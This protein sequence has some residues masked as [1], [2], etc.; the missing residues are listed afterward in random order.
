MYR[1]T[2]RR[3]AALARIAQDNHPEVFLEAGDT[4]IFSSRVIP[5]N[6]REVGAI[7]NALSKRGVRIITES[8]VD[9]TVHVTGHPMREEL[10]ALM[11]W[12]RPRF[13]LPV[14]GEWRHLEAHAELAEMN[15]VEKAVVGGNGAVIRLTQD[16][17][18]VV[19]RVY[20]GRL[21][22][23]GHRLI[24][25]EG[26]LLP[27]RRRL[28]RAGMVSIGVALDHQG[29]MVGRISVD[30]YGSMDRDVD[31]DIINETR[32]DVAQSLERLDRKRR[33]EDGAVEK[34]IVASV[35]QT[36]QDITGKKPL[37]SV[38]IIRI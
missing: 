13:V 37:V 16:S 20:S 12:I 32:N 28:A 8:D 29:K 7:Q 23:D 2:R 24:D 26:L 19:D 9:E 31:G 38:H 6:E 10:T 17:A 34:T 27:Q 3:R 35:K 21:A 36:F 22:L 1:F 33:H 4:A 11:E 25:P 14:H 15:Q 18:K 5:G 30:A